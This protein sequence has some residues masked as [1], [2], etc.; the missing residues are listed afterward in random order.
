VGGY[1]VNENDVVTQKVSETEAVVKWG[2]DPEYKESAMDRFDLTQCTTEQATSAIP[3][4]TMNST[5]R[6]AHIASTLCSA[7]I[8]VRSKL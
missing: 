7:A 3:F 5:A 1:I 4:D 8:I 2:S 6:K